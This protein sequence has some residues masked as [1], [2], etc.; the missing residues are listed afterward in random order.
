MEYINF[1]GLPIVVIMMIPNIIYGIKCPEG[2]QNV[3]HNKLVEI[4]EQ[5]GRYGCFALMCVQIPG[6]FGFPSKL[7]FTSYLLVNGILLLAYCTI[8]IICF[9]KNNLFR[10][11]AL[12]AIPSVIFIFSGIATTCVFLTILGIIFAIC[13]IL[14]SVKSVG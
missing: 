1:F 12:S 9:R 7:W 11:I 6:F 4:F 3:W 13:H 10:A 2:F 5:I 14:I 8:W